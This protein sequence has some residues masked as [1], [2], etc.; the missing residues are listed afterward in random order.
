M[1]V[2]ISLR[3]AYRF[4]IVLALAGWGSVADSMFVGKLA[5]VV[6]PE[7]AKELGLADDVKAKLV[8]LINNREKEAIDKVAKLKGQPQAKQ[9]EAL[10]PFAAESEKLGVLGPDMVGKLQ[11]TD[12]QKKEIGPLVEEFKSVM[13][14]GNDFQKRSARGYYE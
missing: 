3:V 9:I 12:E 2:C 5:L 7:V 13:A 10:A 14:R 8:E 4:G 11:L 6:D 1:R